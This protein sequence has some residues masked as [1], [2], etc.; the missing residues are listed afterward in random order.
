MGLLNI[1]GDNAGAWNWRFALG[2]QHWQF[3]CR[4]KQQEFISALPESFLHQPRCNAVFAKNQAHV[5]RM[6]TER[7][8][9]Q[10]QH[11]RPDWSGNAATVGINGG[12]IER[13]N[14]GAN[15][16]EF[17]RFFVAWLVPLRKNP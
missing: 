12:T 15:C 17:L 16:K 9:K 13:R 5:S 4:V 10:R 3:P 8:M 11:G 2:Y 6:R 7:V 14:G 1:F